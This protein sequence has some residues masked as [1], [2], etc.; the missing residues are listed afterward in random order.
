MSADV[1]I[2]K[3][4]QKLVVEGPGSVGQI[5][6]ESKFDLGSKENNTRLTPKDIPVKT[7]LRYSLTNIERSKPEACLINHE[8]Y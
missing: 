3:S 2:R 4:M 8:K 7:C 1:L 5:H 6:G